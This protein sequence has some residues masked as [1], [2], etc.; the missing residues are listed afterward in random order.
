MTKGVTTSSIIFL[1]RWFT[2]DGVK[3]T[4]A[5][6]S[7]CLYFTKVAEH[8]PEVF[9]RKPLMCPHTTMVILVFNPFVT[10]VSPHI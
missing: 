3:P 9:P 8:L 5:L 7:F 1:Y 10:E 2:A 4:S 6:T